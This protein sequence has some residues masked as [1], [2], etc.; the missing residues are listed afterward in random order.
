MI[1]SFFVIIFFP[2]VIIFFSPK[3]TKKIT[4]PRKKKYS[5]INEVIHPTETPLCLWYDVFMPLPLLFLCTNR[6][7]NHIYFE[8]PAPILFLSNITRTWFQHWAFQVFACPRP[9]F[10]WWSIN[11]MRG[12]NILLISLIRACR[13]I[14][15]SFL[16]FP[17]FWSF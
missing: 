10:C 13:G 5:P 11:F 2:W 16:Q 1:T 3:A 4:H 7:K 12:K 15:R 14:Q 8:V 9:Y 17:Y 6:G